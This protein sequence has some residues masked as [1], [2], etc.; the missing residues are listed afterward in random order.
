MVPLH[1]AVLLA[2][3]QDFRLLLS[4]ISHLQYSGM[5]HSV[6]SIV[7]FVLFLKNVFHSVIIPVQPVHCALIIACLEP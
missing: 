4:Y 3:L 6:L 5:L 7:F 2:V 1:F